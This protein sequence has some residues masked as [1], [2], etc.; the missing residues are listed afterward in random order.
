MS[1]IPS[2]LRYSEDHEWVRP[3][4]GVAKLGITAYAQEQLG[5][6]VY[7]EL[8]AVGQR[9]AA[10]KPFGVVESVKAASDIL[11][12]VSGTVQDVN[13]RLVDE[14][15]LANSDPYG[16]GWIATVELADEGELVGLMDAAAYGEFIASESE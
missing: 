3:E 16:E 10:G 8:P 2:D 11:C 12:P 13:A 1:D 6:I 14:P 4:G 9:V 15:E 5:D 7:I